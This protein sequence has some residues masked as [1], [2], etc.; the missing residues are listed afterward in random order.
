MIKYSRLLLII[1][2]AIPLPLVLFA[3]EDIVVTQAEIEDADAI[4]HE[5]AKV[6]FVDT[7]GNPDN[8]EKILFEF[9]ELLKYNETINGEK[10]PVRQTFTKTYELDSVFIV[11]VT[12]VFDYRPDSHSTRY[13][14]SGPT[15][16]IWSNSRTADVPYEQ[17]KLVR[18][19]HISKYPKENIQVTRRVYDYLKELLGSQLPVKVTSVTE[20]GD[21]NYRIEMGEL[22]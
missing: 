9:T 8:I 6:L 19:G 13:Y 18:K 4:T 21:L 20:D 1:A 15:T 11:N 10:I 16:S 2:I 5:N 17:S 7:D 3:H 14:I 22:D 12:E